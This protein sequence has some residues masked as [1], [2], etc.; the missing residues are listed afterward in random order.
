MKRIFCTSFAGT[1]ALPLLL[2][3]CGNS[4]GAAG[5]TEAQETVPAPETTE[6]VTET[7]YVPNLPEADFAGAEFHV[8][9]YSDEC[10]NVMITVNIFRRTI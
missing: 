8:L 2:L 7:R 3:S 1:A 4:E 10:M 6:A 9:A 5:V